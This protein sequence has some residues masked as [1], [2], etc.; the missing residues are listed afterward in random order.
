MTA[1]SKKIPYSDLVATVDVLLDSCEEDVTCLARELGRLDSAIRSELLVSD[2]LNAYQVFF[3]F[4][5]TAPSDL[6]RERMDLEPASVLV[7]GFKIEEVEL[8]ELLF[9]VRENAPLIVVSDGERIL[10][11]FSGKSAYADGMEYIRNP[12]YN[13]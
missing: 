4:F 12:E 9:C 5:R 10:A 11:T 3:Y 13:S 1:S 6:A 7:Q 8:L 2:L